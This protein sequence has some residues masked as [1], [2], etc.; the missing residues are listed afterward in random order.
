M[1]TLTFSALEIIAG[2][3]YHLLRDD[4]LVPDTDEHTRRIYREFNACEDCLQGNNPSQ[5]GHAYGRF[6]QAKMGAMSI[7]IIF[8]EHSDRITEAFRRG[9]EETH[10]LHAIGRI[11]LLQ[12]RLSRRGLD[13][14]LV[15]YADYGHCREE[16][17][18]LVANIGACHA[19]ENLG[20]DFE[21]VPLKQNPREFRPAIRRYQDAIRHRTL[22]RIIF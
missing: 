21:K 14:D 6:M 4:G 11:G 19:V 2:T 16:D 17:K 13:I 5:S 20:V 1:N 3:K 7:W 9:H 10:V 18:E 22:A 12:Q 15:Q 8:Y